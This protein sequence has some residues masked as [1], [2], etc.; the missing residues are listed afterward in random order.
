[1]IIASCGAVLPEAVHAADVLAKEGVAT[2]VID[3]SSPDRIYHEWRHELREAAGSARAADLDR[4]HLA[5]LITPS[6]RRAPIVTVHDASS[7]ALAWLGSVFGQRTIPVGVD[8][9]GQSGAIV[10]LYDAYQLLP[11]HIANAALVAVSGGV[12]PKSHE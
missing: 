3:V 1:V 2:T 4:L 7:H 11:D 5:T 6:E 8:A 12:D 10:D 9:F